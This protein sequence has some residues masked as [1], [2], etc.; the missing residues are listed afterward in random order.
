[1]NTNENWELLQR[2]FKGKSEIKSAEKK[3]AIPSKTL[4]EQSVQALADL[5]QKLVLKAV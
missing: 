2:L 1:V 4:N 5:E 3:V